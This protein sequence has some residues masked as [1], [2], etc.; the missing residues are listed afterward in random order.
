MRV[1]RI[2]EVEGRILEALRGGA[3][4]A[5][6]AQAAGV[7]PGTLSAWAYR[8]RRGHLRFQRI[9]E[10]V[11]RSRD[12]GRRHAITAAVTPRQSV[13]AAVTPRQGVNPEFTADNAALLPDRSELLARLDQQSQ[14]GS[15][16]ATLALLREHDREQTPATDPE[17]AAW[18]ARIRALAGV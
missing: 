3:S 8:G 13:T 14:D 9:A 2:D 6:A 10:A 18:R 5:D 17:V 4:V 11:E 15:V 16:Q 7:A 12:N 1:S